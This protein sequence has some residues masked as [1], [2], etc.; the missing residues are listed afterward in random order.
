MVSSSHL[1]TSTWHWTTLL[2]KWVFNVVSLT[3]VSIINEIMDM[4]CIISSM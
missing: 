2:F 3:H 4:I 1:E